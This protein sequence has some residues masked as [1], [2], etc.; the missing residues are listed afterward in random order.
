LLKLKLNSEFDVSRF[1]KPGAKAND[2]LGTNINK[3]MSKDYFVVVCAGSNGIS[4]NNAKEGLRNIINFVKI[5]SHTNI[6][7]M[8]ALHRHDLVDWS[9]V[10]KA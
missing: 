9:C 1:V 6:I 7:V 5:T 4:K 8:E 2:I 10:N 3:D